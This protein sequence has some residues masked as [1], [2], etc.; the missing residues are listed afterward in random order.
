MVSKTEEEEIR[1][2]NFLEKKYL[3]KK[4]S[5]SHGNHFNFIFSGEKIRILFHY[6]STSIFYL[7]IPIIQEIKKNIRKI[8]RVSIIT[9]PMK[10]GIFSSLK[11]IQEIREKEIIKMVNIETKEK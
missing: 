7:K 9:D 4:K 5:Y 2:T 3:S 10:K 6:F 8:I 1:V 11:E